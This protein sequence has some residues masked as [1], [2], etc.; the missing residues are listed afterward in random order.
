MSGKLTLILGGARSGKSNYAQS[1][2]EQHAGQV[3]YVATAIAGDA[4]MAAAHCLAP[5]QPAHQLAYPGSARKS[6]E[7]HTGM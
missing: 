5:V 4:E 1:L 7:S 3:L 2:A 6:W